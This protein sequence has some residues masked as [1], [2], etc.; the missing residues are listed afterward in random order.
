MNSK[1]SNE[2]SQHPR[3]TS[4]KFRVDAFNVGKR[5][6]LV[7]KLFVERQS[8]TSIE[9]VAVKDRNAQNPSHEVKVR[10]VIRIYT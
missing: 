3:Q 2:N 8:E 1:M 9:A 5:N 4:M 6:R 7:E 10:K